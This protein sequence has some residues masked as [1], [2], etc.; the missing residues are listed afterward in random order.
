MSI[1]NNFLLYAFVF[2]MMLN[3]TT[4]GLVLAEEKKVTLKI[5]FGVVEGFIEED[6]TGPGYDL[7]RAVVQRLEKEGYS[8]ETQLLPFKRVLRSFQLGRLDVAFPIVND[9]PFSR[10]GYKKWG[11]E[12]MPL[13]STPLFSSGGFVIFTRLNTPK[14]DR[15]ESLKDLRIGVITGAFIPSSLKPP[16]TYQVEEIYSG[17]QGFEMLKRGRIDAYVVHKRWGQSLLKRDP[18]TT[19][20]HGAEFN[21]IIGGFLCQQNG[22]GASILAQINHAIGAMIM[23]GTYKKILDS[24]PLNKFVIRYP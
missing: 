13:Y 23:D 19:I 12:K 5:G 8:V 18:V 16:T 20:H 24:Y 6:L 10:G 22:L 3:C 7:M 2:G 1:R 9:G 11:F 21:N 4:F 14:I 15:I 17:K